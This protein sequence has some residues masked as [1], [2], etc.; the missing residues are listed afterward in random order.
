MR[1]GLWSKGK[2]MPYDTLSQSEERY[3]AFID[4]SCEAIWCFEFDPPLCVTWPEDEQIRHAFENSFLTHWNDAMARMYG[5]SQQDEI[6]G[7]RLGELLNPSDPENVESLRTF[8]RS[9]YNL[10]DVQCRKTSPGGAAVWILNN[11]VA[12]IEDGAVVRAWVTQRD[13]TEHKLVEE[14]LLESESRLR[15]I[16]E[17]E[18]E[19]VKLVGADGTLLEMNPAGLRML[20][21]DSLQQV[22]GREIVDVVDPK[23]RSRFVTLTQK[24][25][26]GESGTLEFEVVGFKGTRRWLEAHATPLRNANGD[27]T[28]ALSVTRDITERKRNASDRAMLL[29]SERVARNLAEYANVLNTELLLREQTA[30]AEA[31]AGRREWQT[32]FDTLADSVV[33]VDQNDHILRA[34]RGFYEGVGLSPE[35]CA[36]RTV[37]ELKHPTDGPF[38]TADDCPICNLRSKR[39]RNVIELSGGIVSNFP[40]IVSVDPIF[41]DQGEVTAVVQIIRDLS[42]L[43]RARE[44][45]DR[46]RA[47]L[48]ATIEQMAQG[49][50]VFDI[51]GRVVR[52]NRR[53]QQILSLTLEEMREDHTGKLAEG[54][55]SDRDGQIIAVSDLPIQTS[56]RE[57][58]VVDAQ[59]WYEREEGRRSLLN[60]T[61]S[62][63]FND[64][65][66]LMGA[67]A[68]IRDVTEQQRERERTLQ[69]DKLRALGQLASGVAHNFNNS[70]AAVIGYTQLA[71]PKAK[72]EDLRKYLKVVERSAKD[73]ARMVGRIQNFSRASSRKDEF[74]TVRVC[75]TVR[76]ARD[77]TQ[78]RWRDD[79]ESLGLKYEVK[80]DLA[81]A[82]DL[83]VSGHSSELREVFVNLIL[84]GLDAMPLGGLITISASVNKSQVI[85]SFSDSGEGMTEEIKRRIFEPFFTTKGTSGLGMG[86]SESYRI[87]ERHG[88]GIE[89]E[90]QPRKG[91]TFTVSLPLAVS[92]STDSQFELVPGPLSALN[93]LVIDDEELVR[94]VLAE[95]LSQQGHTVTVAPGCDEALLLI[96]RYDFD[97]VFTDLAM[98]KTDGIATATQIKIRRPHLK[99]VMMS[100][101]GAERA[102]ERASASHC[103]DAAI[104]KPFNI[105]EIRAALKDLMQKE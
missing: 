54:R 53:A 42:D 24:V 102:N 39:E 55:F 14:R 71:L 4:H 65:D 41:N 76:D 100:G 28:A 68:L 86:L 78:P 2:T 26:Q 73:A 64:Q 17:S 69:A 98:P 29:S 72:E 83:V 52:A 22:L 46:E 93:I 49:L 5:L 30:R 61:A 27:I 57:R 84:N 47:F 63:F 60:I 3:R 16:I 87:V 66:K 97:V 90:S 32:T 62:P 19:C 25:F 12:V 33:I 1:A 101:Y 48:N 89:V 20:E 80:L 51:H 31:E 94:A 43:Y 8:I 36:G 81:V 70:L 37:R 34:N 13:I 92:A 88:G 7:M 74:T 82:D 85:L 44:E 50:V 77:L 96:D 59:L 9:R 45:A 75:D 105:A 15:T 67:V 104:S 35:Q 23:H 18:P 40:L 38:V 21:A 11:V 79:A 91:T 6:R 56:L 95:I 10:I 99:I 103:I 58:R